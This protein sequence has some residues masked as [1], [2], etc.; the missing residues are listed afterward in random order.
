MMDDSLFYT[1]RE[2][3]EEVASDSED[4]NSKGKQKEEYSETSGPSFPSFNTFGWGG[5]ISKALEKAKKQSEEVVNVY[6][7]DLTEFASVVSADTT[8]TFGSLTKKFSELKNTL[9]DEE[10]TQ[11]LPPALKT[12]SR[13][14]GASTKTAEQYVSRWGSGLTK[15]ISDA[16]TIAP[17]EE[18]QLEDDSTKKILIMD[19]KEVQLASIRSKE[20]TYLADPTTEEAADPEDVKK[21]EEFSENFKVADYTDQITDLLKENPE[22]Q[23]LMQQIVPTQVPYEKFWLRYYFRVFEIDEKEELRKQLVNA[24]INKDEE[25]FNWDDDEE[26]EEEEQ[27]QKKESVESVEGQ[28]EKVQD[29]KED[30][31]AHSSDKDETKEEKLET[32]SEDSKSPQ[33]SSGATPRKS[34]ESFE[35]VQEGKQKSEPPRNKREKSK[36]TDSGAEE[37]DWSDW[38]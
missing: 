37:D 34:E 8:Q 12:T 24:A 33:L 18:E 4:P 31:S 11:N 35:L 22:L 27:V 32:V 19:R 28:E 30:T 15:L 17:S 16:I 13:I 38:E 20:D 25:L 6:K 36:Q 2:V 7:K 3:S 14:I 21:F 1:L 5:T 9:Q 29:S 26:E 23:E 10:N